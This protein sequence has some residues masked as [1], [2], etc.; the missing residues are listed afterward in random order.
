[1]RPR[2]D[3]IPRAT[4]AWW[5]LG[6][7]FTLGVVAAGVVAAGVALWENIDI[8]QLTPGLVAS[9]LEAPEPVAA[10]AASVAP[11]GFEA[12]IFESDRNR[13]YFED[14]RFYS[15]QIARWRGHLQ[16]VGAS[17]RTVSDGAGL[18]GLTADD[19]LVLPEAPCI[20][21]EELAAIGAHMARGGSMVANWATAVRD[22]AC[23]WR[24]WGPLLSLTGA[25]DVRELP[26]RTGLYLTVPGGQATSPG[27]D[28]GTRIELRPDPAIALR[29][30]GERV[31]WSDW[32]LNPEPDE[33]GA[34]ADVAV[35]TTRTEAGGRTT[36]F[37]MRA[38][39]GATP[40]DSARLHRLMTNGIL[41]AAGTA[42]AAPAPWPGAARAALVFAMDVEGIDSWVNA[43]DIAAMFEQE[44]VPASFYPVSGLVKDDARLAAALLAAGE[45]GTQTVDHRPLAGLTGQEQVLR[46]RRSSDQ[47][48]EWTGVVPAGLHPPE[49]AVDEFTLRAWR[50]AGGRYVLASND[51]RSASPEIHETSEG[52]V[53]L[54][55]RVLKD[56][57]TVVVRDVT[58]RSQRLAEAFLADIRKM[59]AIGGLAVVAGHTQIVTSGPRLE[60][61]RTV[62]NSVRREGGW[63]L[64]RGDEVADW[65]LLRAQVETRWAEAGPGPGRGFQATGMPDL[66][67]SLAADRSFDDEGPEQI[68]VLRDF[69]MDIVAPRLQEGAIP[70]VDGVSVEFI[71]ETWGMRMRLGTLETGTVRRISFVTVSE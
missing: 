30:S 35:A 8:R 14:S 47:I 41:W 45:V 38:D 63:W 64:A 15:D 49:E 51:A 56:D 71:E 26:A 66:L 44:R 24:G 28:P 19:V 4:E 34:G 58:L 27:I 5:W 12:V 6:G 37:A 70:V 52:R 29:L 9:P 46:L 53:A 17:V 59:R 31:Y 21:A 22:D 39:Q 11:G 61:I 67:V 57:Y 25:E 23:G 7:T 13:E 1:M 60:A 62:A 3:P 32:A 20:S 68:P 36:W 40:T 48:A 18:R 43:M 33:E 10:A 65:W 50:Q 16:G 42:H 54:L 55:P 69:W 2:R